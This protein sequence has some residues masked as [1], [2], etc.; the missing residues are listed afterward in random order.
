MKITSQIA[1]ETIG[2]VQNNP[3]QKINPLTKKILSIT[4]CVFAVLFGLWVIRNSISHFKQIKQIK[5]NITKKKEI[6]VMENQKFSSTAPTYRTIQRV[7]NVETGGSNAQGV[8]TETP[9]PQEE[10]DTRINPW[11]ESKISEIDTEFTST[12]QQQGESVACIINA[13]HLTKNENN[14]SYSFNNI[15]TL[16]QRVQAD[17]GEVF[18]EG[19]KFRDE[20][21]IGSWTGFLIEENTLLTAAHCICKKDSDELKH[22]QEIEAMRIVFGFRMIDTH[23]CQ[24][25]FEEKDV[26]KIARVIDRKFSWNGDDKYDW[27]LLRLDRKVVGRTPLKLNFSRIDQGNLYSL[28]YPIGLPLKCTSQA[29]IKDSQEP[30][31]IRG[32]LPTFEKN[33]G[34]PVFSLDS[35]EVV[36]MLVRGSSDYIIDDNYRG[37]NITRS[38]VANSESSNEIFEVIQRISALDSIK[39]FMD[40][41]IPSN[42]LNFQFVCCVNNGNPSFIAKG[43]GE[44]FHLPELMADASCKQCHRNVYGQISSIFCKNVSVSYT[45]SDGDRIIKATNKIIGAKGHHFPTKGWREFKVSCTPLNV[46]G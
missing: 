5:T 20:P 15:H 28:G 17:T 18:G 9:H 22:F 19:E 38:R 2:Y 35:K 11:V 21:A 29:I 10:L 4:L 41:C 3:F 16:A 13:D 27:A 6:V 26:Y 46:I 24:Q 31:I 14:Q 45:M 34:S 30:C 36:G 25:T 32:N 1:L 7:L 44:F 23:T 39:T 40:P 42:G 8:A 43:F 12:I 33:S 37:L